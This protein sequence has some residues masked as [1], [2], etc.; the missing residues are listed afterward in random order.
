MRAASS[1]LGVRARIKRIC[2]ASSCSRVTGSPTSIV[3]GDPAAER[4]AAAMM[5]SGRSARSSRCP[6]G[7]DRGPLDGVAQLAE[8]ARPA[9]PGQ[10]LAGLGREALDLLAQLS[11][12]ERQEVL[13]QGRPVG[14]FA[15][16]GQR[17]LD[18]VEAEQQVLAELPGGDGGVEVAVRRRDQADVGRAGPRLADPLVA[19][20]LEESEQLGLERERQVADLVEEQ[21]PPFRRG[22]LALGIGD[23]TGERAPSVAE[24]VALEQF[25]D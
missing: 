5:R 7:E 16:R 15:E 25:G 6:G 21:G 10:D 8:V 4:D 23:R 11:S 24:Q 17:Q 13:R 14:P 12:E 1:R 19:A 20:L 22:D 2:S 18:D 3:A 9:V